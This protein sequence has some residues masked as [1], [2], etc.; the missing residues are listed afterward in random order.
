MPF[1]FN[2]KPPRDDSFSKPEDNESSGFSDFPDADI[3]DNNYMPRFEHEQ[4]EAK[5][6]HRFP[7]DNIHLGDINISKIFLAITALVAIIII[8]INRIIILDFLLQL[9]ATLLLISFAI[10]FIF[11]RKRR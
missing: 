11:R 10:W 4:R 2:Q 7:I 9:A 6:T 3:S 5:R 8:W 1:D